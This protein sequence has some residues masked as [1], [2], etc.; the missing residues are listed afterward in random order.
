MAKYTLPFSKSVKSDHNQNFWYFQNNHIKTTKIFSVRSSP[1][2]SIFKKNA[3][4]SSPDPAKIAFN[5]DPVRSSPVRV[6]LCIPKLHL[7]HFLQCFLSNVLHFDYGLPTEMSGLW[8]Y[9]VRVQ[10][11][12]DEHGSGLDR[13]GSGLKTILAGSGLDRTANFWKLANQD[14]IGLRKF[15]LF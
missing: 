5:S 2:P 15:L 12:R 10:S 4:W 8:K 7:P 14:W 9:S 13:T 3:V 1:D 6:Y 11:C